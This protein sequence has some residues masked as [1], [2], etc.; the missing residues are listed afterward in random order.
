[1]TLHPGPADRKL[2]LEIVAPV[3]VEVILE[4]TTDLGN[5]TETQRVPGQGDGT[6][7][8]GQQLFQ[9]STIQGTATST[10]L[11]LRLD[12]IIQRGILFAPIAARFSG[13]VVF[14]YYSL[15][16][17]VTRKDCA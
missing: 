9:T 17:A 12:Q 5:W 8:Q 4:T 3:G 13:D 7:V 11:T 16:T 2:R 14:P 10:A 6:P 1:M 15:N